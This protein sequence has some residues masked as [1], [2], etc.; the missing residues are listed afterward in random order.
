MHHNGNGNGNGAGSLAPPVRNSYFYGKLL[1]V[2]HLELEQRYFL[3]RRRMLNRLAVGWGVLCGLE[4]RV[5]GEHLVLG[6]GV[7]IDDAGREIVVDAPHV[8]EEPLAL[9]DACGVPTGEVSEHGPAVLCL[10]YHECPADPSPVLVSDCEVQERCAPGAIRERYRLLVR[11]PDDVCPPRGLTPEQ[12]AAIFGTHGGAG[13]AGGDLT[14]VGDLSHGQ[15]GMHPAAGGDVVGVDRNP[16]DPGRASRALRDRICRVL[17]DPCAEGHGCCVPVALIGRDRDGTLVADGCAARTRLYSN[18]TLLDLILCL[19]ERVEECCRS[20]PATETP[21]VV[22]QTTPKPGEQM[23]LADLRGAIGIAAGI[24]AVTFDR[25]MDSGRLGDPDPW[26]RAWIVAPPNADGASAVVR[27]PL[28]LD[29]TTNQPFGGTNGFT[30]VYRIRGGQKA[31]SMM[32]RQVAVAAG[33]SAI[34]V[35]LQIRADDAATQIVDTEA[36]AVL[37]DADFAA[38]G[39]DAATLDKLWAADETTVRDLWTSIPPA[40]GGT[41]PSGDGTAGGRLHSYFEVT[42]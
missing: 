3:D 29:H 5:A 15:I 16:R 21:P 31:M 4:V 8:V 13:A 36:P 14:H 6:P 11:D 35:V 24:L 25:E 32:S 10:C 2:P 28:L 7:A 27:L 22:V 1:D 30:A 23:T 39:I 42:R 41:L 37:L 38:T 9:T 26:L 20:H 12:C 40:G 18:E 17:D 19:A 34:R 33:D